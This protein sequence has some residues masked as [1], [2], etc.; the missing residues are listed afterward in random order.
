METDQQALERWLHDEL[1]QNLVA[2]RS[3][4]KAIMEENSESVDD[5]RELAAMI[6]QAADMSYRAAYDLMQEL[7]VQNHVHLPINKGL[8]NCLLDARLKEKQIEHQFKVDNGLDGLDEFTKA[9]I[10]RSARA[11]I[12][13]SNLC[14]STSELVFDLHQN[15]PETTGRELKLKLIYR[16]VIDIPPAEEILIQTL[17][18]RIEAINGITHLESDNRHYLELNLYLCPQGVDGNTAT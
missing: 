11:F 7:R 9:I 17:C 8:E 3:F 18:K 5:T 6:N 1:G 10:L 2:I 16:G 14:S 15:E 13:Y 12:N 4:S